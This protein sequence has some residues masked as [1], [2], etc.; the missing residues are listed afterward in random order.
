MDISE[1]IFTEP[2]AVSDALANL[3]PL[4]HLAGI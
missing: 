2:D 3:E 4:R 1:D